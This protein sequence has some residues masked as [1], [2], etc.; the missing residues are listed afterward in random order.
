MTT[1][2]EVEIK[3]ELAPASLPRLKKIPLIQ[4]IKK[5]PRRT[6]EVSTYFDTRNREL[7]KKGVMLRVRRIGDRFVQTIKSGKPGLFERGEWETEIASDKPD[8]DLAAGTALEPLVSKK[9][10]RRLKPLF[11]TRVRRT[12]YP[13]SNEARSIALTLDRGTIDSEGRSAPL[14][15][16]ELELER[17]N[18]AELFAVAR[19]LGQA[20]PVRLAFKSKSDRGYQ[21][22]DGEEGLP[23]K[24]APVDLAAGTTKRDAFKIIGRA[25]LKQIVGNEAALLRGDAEGVH[26]MRVGLRRLRAAM[27]LIS[28][29]LRDAQTAAIKAELKW[30]AGELTDARELEVLMKSVVAPAKKQHANRDGLPSLSRELAERHAAA[31]AQAQSAVSSRRFRA[32]TLETAAWIEIG[33]WSMPQEDSPGEEPIEISA[34]EQLER[35]W[36][37]VRKK[38]RIFAELDAPSRHRLRIQVKKLR[39][40]AE[41]FA[42][43]FEGRRAAKRRERFLPA[44]GRLQDGLGDL[45]DIAVHENLLNSMGVRR[46][47]SSLRRAYAAGLLTGHE[48]VRRDAAMAAAAKAHAELAGIKPFWR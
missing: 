2:D 8:L 48:D 36:R 43:L 29:L 16:I 39:Y 27:S 5:T 18:L 40:A 45:N 31:L 32:L 23:V 47:R 20:L 6:T 1:P 41:F 44:L 22:M 26:Q 37:K 34:A 3:L 35:R 28:D 25:C 9:L 30:L 10:R 42:K 11:E 4:P 15:E 19:E 21:L 24:A 7:H 38:G 13:L 17:G 14:C 12:V 46:K 33:N